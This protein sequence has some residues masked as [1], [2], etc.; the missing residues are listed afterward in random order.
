MVRQ[1]NWSRSCSAPF[2]TKTGD[3]KF[4]PRYFLY[5]EIIRKSKRSIGAMKYIPMWMNFLC[6]VRVWSILFSLW[7]TP[8]STNSFSAVFRF[9]LWRIVF[10]AMYRFQRGHV[11]TR[12]LIWVTQRSIQ[13]FHWSGPAPYLSLM[14]MDW[15]ISQTCSLTLSSFHCAVKPPISY[16][17][18]MVCAAHWL[19]PT[20]AF[21]AQMWTC[22]VSIWIVVPSAT[23][24]LGN[25]KASRNISGSQRWS[26]IEWWISNAH[27]S[28]QASGVVNISSGVIQCGS[29]GEEGM[30]KVMEIVSN[31]GRRGGYLYGFA[32]V[33]LI[34]WHHLGSCSASKRFAWHHRSALIGRLNTWVHQ[35]DN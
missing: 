15:A 16:Q 14:L 26:M 11:D 33:L 21:S 17:I 22:R 19:T 30:L 32:G 7:R 31:V 6:V 28:Q 13:R 34:R 27:F 25:Q 12:S 3:P 29:K 18:P 23:T 35:K 24:N 8:T 9:W 5:R 20:L 10:S 1:G 2:P 4:L